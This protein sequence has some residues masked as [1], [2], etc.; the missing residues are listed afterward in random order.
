M[1]PASAQ[2][3]DGGVLR[4][5]GGFIGNAGITLAGAGIGAVLALANEV[6]AAHFLGVAAYGLYAIA[7]MLAKM[8]EILAVFGLPLS[9]LHYLPVHLN[10]REHGDALGTIL[11]AVLLPLLLG[12]LFAVGLALGGDWM[13]AHIFG[14][15]KAGRFIA[16][17]GLAI[18]L[19]A[20]ADLLGN[21]A[22]GFGS[23]LP[24]IVIRNLVP[25]LCSMA[26]L[27]V[28]TL[29]G[30][31]PMAALFS[32]VGGIAVGTAIGAGFVWQLI[33]RHIGRARP[34]MRI[35]RL[36]GYAAPVMLN[37]IVSLAMVWTDLFLLSVFTNASTVGIYRGCMQIVLG[38]DLVWNACSAAT[39]PIYPVLIADRQHAQ[40]QAI[41][42]GAVRISTLLSIP[43]MLVILVNGGDILGLLGPAF[44]AGASA[45]AVLAFGQ[46]LKVVFGN[47]S[48]VLIV[49]GR[50]T[51]EAGNGT[52]A[53]GL[54]LILNL[55]LVPRYGLLGAAA[56]TATAQGTLGVLRAVQL[57]RV[58][59]LRTLDRAI[60]RM[61]LATVPLTAAI[62]I[63]CGLAGIA[64][65]SGIGALILRLGIMT[66][67]IGAALWQFGLERDDRAAVLRAVR[68]GRRAAA[69]A[70]AP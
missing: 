68:G 58:M 1:T 2:A 46:F 29:R 7:L 10:R 27:I 40:L 41:Y 54:N 15:S 9:V 18:P 26:V 24:Y 34:V 44:T 53:A 43:I 4:G 28:L 56:A 17:A 20:L 50:Q 39:A 33:R 36:Y 67:M 38:F 30:G 42:A 21:V 69:A 61:L 6:L 31:P 22:R 13:A 66:A 51:L 52:M 60:L 47:A 35:G 12:L 62:W 55:L 49:G 16:I 57:R 64:P 37:A 45:L 70:V 8:G 11:G 25:A 5:S 63:G 59:A 14:E 19:L 23:A 32:Y 48:V 3:D 65:G